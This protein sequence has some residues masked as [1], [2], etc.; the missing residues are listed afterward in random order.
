MIYPIVLG[1][2]LGAPWGLSFSPIQFWWLGLLQLLVLLVLLNTRYFAHSIPRVFAFAWSF[3]A[4]GL[5]LGVSWL[6]ISLHV[7]GE[8]PALLAVLSVFGFALYL[9]LFAALS[10]MAWVSCRR[11]SSASW[12]PCWNAFLWAAFWSF[13]EWFRGYFLT[14]FAWLSL[15]DSLVDS[16][17]SGLLPWL[18]NHGA[19]FFVLWVGSALVLIIMRSPKS[20]QIKP[21]MP[22]FCLI[23]VMALFLFNKPE[24]REVDEFKLVG[25]QPNVQQDIKFDPTFILN[26][27]KKVFQLGDMGLA[28]LPN[29]G[30][31]IFPE[32][33]NPL[34]WQNSPKRWLV[35]FRDYAAHREGVVITGAAIEDQGLHFNSVVLFDGS[36]SDD[37]LVTPSKRHDKRHLVPFGETIPFGF[38]WFVSL[39]NMPMGEF[40]PGSGALKPL[41]S[42][43][44]ALAAT[45]CYED[46]FSG[47]FASLVRQAEQEPTLLLN[48]SNL[49]WFD[50]SWALDQH[51]QMGRVRSA[52]HQKPTIRV[53]NTGVSGVISAEG[54]WL[55]RVPAWEDQVW[56]ASV[57]GR[58][59]L[60]PYAQFG[61]WFYL[62]IWGLPLLLLLCRLLA[63]WPY[64]K[65]V[66]I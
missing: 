47:E 4:C 10:A 41:L 33:V 27:M 52:E 58:I 29:E 64:N 22:V 12:V 45:I 34:L 3:G 2:L 36:E 59:G 11:E 40:H 46:T 61:H 8:L 54:Q 65:R 37:Q 23:G 39:L 51:A 60:T 63:I 6:Y 31:L 1:V 17:F 43:G 13:F 25:I 57:H 32:T 15:G 48:L 9:G 50:Q 66:I 49:A 18:G 5:G 20:I 7:Y 55:K 44:N 53:T 62:F 14:G 24:T 30:A 19:L 16:P 56:Q 21:V 42:Q 38:K 35:R 28:V 26:N